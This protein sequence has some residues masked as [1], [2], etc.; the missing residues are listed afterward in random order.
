MIN[1]SVVGAT[2]GGDV[3]AS[4]YW[5]SKGNIGNEG[6]SSMSR[7][8][9]DSVN[10][11]SVSKS[12]AS[13]SNFGR[14][15]SRKQERNQSLNSNSSTDQRKKD[16]SLVKIKVGKRLMK[17]P[18]REEYQ[19]HVEN[20][21]QLKSIVERRQTPGK[22]AKTT[23][24]SGEKL[25]K[26]VTNFRKKRLVLAN[27][28]DHQPDSSPKNIGNKKESKLLPSLIPAKESRNQD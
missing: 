17:D 21:T 18:A 20:A 1:D 8:D 24:N 5:V 28:R 19:D 16:S 26:T 27:D 22:N 25:T 7:D 15:P 23:R 6:G 11:Q 14:Y 9:G 13:I 2:T 10:R 3:M 4:T 12:N